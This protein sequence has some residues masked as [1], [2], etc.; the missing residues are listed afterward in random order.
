MSDRSMIQNSVAVLFLVWLLVF[1]VAVLAEQGGPSPLMQKRG[2]LLQTASVGAAATT[3]PSLFAGTAK[4]GLFAPFPARTGAQAGSADRPALWTDPRIA[5]GGSGGAPDVVAIRQMIGLAESRRDGYDAVV[6]SA[7]IKPPAPPTRLTIGQIFDWI[8]A[9]PGQN[10]AIGRYQ[11]IPATLRRLVR[12]AGLPSHQVFTPAVQDRLA[13]RL[14]AE[15]GL[16][17]A[18]AGRIGRH[19]FMNNLAKIW[20]GLPTASGRSHYHGVAGNRATVSWDRMDAELSRHFPRR[21]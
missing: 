4:G 9:T 16:A 10:H 12:D 8:R 15:A 20:A 14:L 17:E 18:R 5:L 11:F 2:A 7:R 6:W 21:G 13:D 3:G 19:Q 1:P